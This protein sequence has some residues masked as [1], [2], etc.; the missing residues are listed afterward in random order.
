MKKCSNIAIDQIALDKL[1]Y[2]RKKSL[3]DFRDRKSHTEIKSSPCDHR[4]PVT[5]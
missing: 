2:I 3:G 4:W 1:I 5:L